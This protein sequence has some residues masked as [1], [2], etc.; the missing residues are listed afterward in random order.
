MVT[1]LQHSGLHQVL[2]WGFE[3]SQDPWLREVWASVGLDHMRWEI[4]GPTQQGPP[5]EEPGKMYTIH[6]WGSSEIP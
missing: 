3:F 1:P 5:C 2:L 6:M 4:M